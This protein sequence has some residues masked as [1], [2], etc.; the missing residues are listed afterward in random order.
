[1]T[2]RFLSI[3]GS[4]LFLPRC[5]IV[6]GAVRDPTNNFGPVDRPGRLIYVAINSGASDDPAEIRI[7]VTAH[8]R[9]NPAALD[10]D[11]AKRA[12]VQFAQCLDGLAAREIGDDAVYPFAEIVP[13]LLTTAS[14][15]PKTP[16]KPPPEMVPELLTV[17]RPKARPSNVPV[18]EAPGT[19]L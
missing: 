10:A 6:R 9:F 17:P 3:R 15:L 12:I 13:E 7:D 8:G 11:I 16:K 2:T 18:T 4:E 19:M 5:V 14:L 1:M